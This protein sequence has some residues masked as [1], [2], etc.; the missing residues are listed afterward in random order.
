MRYSCPETSVSR[1]LKVRPPQFPEIFIFWKLKNLYWLA[2]TI[3]MYI[4]RGERIAGKRYGP[5]MIIE[6]LPNNSRNVH[7]SHSV[8]YMNWLSISPRYGRSQE[9]YRNSNVLASV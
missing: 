8:P 9:V 6:G 1:S 2:S 5:S 7:L 4:Y 3:D